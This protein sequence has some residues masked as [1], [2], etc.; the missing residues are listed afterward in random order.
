MKTWLLGMFES[1]ENNF[2]YETTSR[3]IDETSDIKELRK[4]TKDLLNLYIKHKEVSAKVLR[5]Y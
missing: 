4:V 1:I 2:F 3:Q 5:S